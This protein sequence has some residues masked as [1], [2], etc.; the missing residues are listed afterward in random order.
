MPPSSSGTGIGDSE[1]HKCLEFFGND[2]FFR[3]GQQT[4]AR[5][6][7]ERGI[8]GLGRCGC[9]DVADADVNLNGNLCAFKIRNEGHSDAFVFGILGYAFRF[10][11]LGIEAQAV[12]V[13]FQ[14][15]EFPKNM[16]EALWGIVTASEEIS[17]PCRTIA[18]FR[19]Q[20]EEQRAFQNENVTVTGAAQPE[21]NTLEPVLDAD[22]SEIHVA[23]ARE[24]RELLADGSREILWGRFGQL[25]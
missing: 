23:L 10:D 4:R 16:S 12:L 22:Q 25:E 21:E 24:V 5:E 2:R 17:I 7:Q 13:D 19:P 9:D 8:V 18:L 20:L 6:F 3:I 11:G 15:A 1:F 14:D